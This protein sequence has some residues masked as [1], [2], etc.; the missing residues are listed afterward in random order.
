MNSF[1]FEYL[2]TLLSSMTYSFSIF[3]LGVYLA[4]I[5]GIGIA[6]IKLFCET[7]QLLHSLINAIFYT[8]ESLPPYPFLIFSTFYFF[9]YWGVTH[10]K[11]ISIYGI[12]LLSGCKLSSDIV[13]NI[14]SIPK[15][16][17]EL[18][19]QLGLNIFYFLPRVIFKQIFIATLPP[20][21]FHAKEILRNLS[22]TSLWGI[23]EYTGEIL[24]LLTIPM[25]PPALF[26]FLILFYTTFTFLIDL[27][28]EM[29]EKYFQERPLSK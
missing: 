27:A 10:L 23:P 7:H 5:F 22:I 15:E 4:I 13:K 25:S 8:I 24:S 18:R 29:T 11:T 28:S 14:K 1:S 9:P 2:P 17:W 19:G 6:L 20:V 16:Q 21:F 12:G 26:F 3:I